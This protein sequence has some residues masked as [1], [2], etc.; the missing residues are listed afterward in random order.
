MAGKNR[1]L[2]PVLAPLALGIVTALA[3]LFHYLGKNRALVTI[4]NRTGIDMMGGQLRITSLPKEQEVGEI[5]AGDSA[6]VLFESFGDGHYVFTGQF[7][8]GKAMQDS[9]GQVKSGASYRDEIL[10][11]SCND[12]L[13]AEV[14]QSAK[15]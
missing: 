2:I 9:G 7:Q 14:S 12:T 5:K 13:V 4:Q 6:K 10:L 11:R 15:D 8:N 1:A 3:F